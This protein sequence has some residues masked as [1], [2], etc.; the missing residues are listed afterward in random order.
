MYNLEGKHQ[1]NLQG[2]FYIFYYFYNKKVGQWKTN[3]QQ[4]D[5][6]VKNAV[7]KENNDLPNNVTKIIL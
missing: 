4:H 6:I 7:L 1:D 5:K 3:V 2:Y